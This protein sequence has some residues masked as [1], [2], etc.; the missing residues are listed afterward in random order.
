MI[1]TETINKEL[2]NV[3]VIL[4]N[5]RRLYNHN[6]VGGTALALYLGHRN[7]YDLDLFT[8]KPFDEKSL[9][10]YL[11]ERYD[12]KRKTIFKNTLMGEINNVKVDFI[13]HQHNNLEEPITTK[14]GLRISSIKDIAAMKLNAIVGSGKRVKD[15]VD[16]AYLSNKFSLNQMLS[17]YENKYKITNSVIVIRSLTYFVDINHSAAVELINANYGWGNIKKRINEMVENN[18]EI[19]KFPP[20]DQNGPGIDRS[21]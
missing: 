7:S 16:I 12:F 14:Q 5:D 20:I 6:L 19:F 21:T 18:N 9:D 8:Q 17:F 1:Y 15:F 13:A 10:K 3:L 11:V 2:Y 4:M